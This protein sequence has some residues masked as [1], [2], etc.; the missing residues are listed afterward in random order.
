MSVNKYYFKLYFVLRS[1]LLTMLWQFQMHSKGTQPYI[2][3]FPFSP[4]LPSNPGRH[5]ALNITYLLFY[6]F[7]KIRYR[8]CPLRISPF[9]S[10]RIVQIQV[11]KASREAR[12]S[13]SD[14]WD[15]SQQI[16]PI[17][18]SRK[19]QISSDVQTKWEWENEI[20]SISSILT[21]SI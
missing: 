20:E 7:R 3:M 15:P 6:D 9:V 17:F 11:T 13:S 5:L 4:K 12:I 18:Y 19:N 1:N 10:S 2:N 21:Q 8:S 16:A 14:K